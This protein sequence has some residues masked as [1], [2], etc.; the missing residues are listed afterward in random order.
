MSSLALFGDQRSD[1]RWFSKKVLTARILFPT[2]PPEFK[3]V[4]SSVF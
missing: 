1:T 2:F 4:T 3:Y